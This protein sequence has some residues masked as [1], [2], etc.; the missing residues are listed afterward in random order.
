MKCFNVNV[1]WK[2]DEA[3]YRKEKRELVLKTIEPICKAFGIQ[4][5]DYEY[6]SRK[7][8]LVLEDTRI[9]CA[10]NSIAATVK[11]LIS[12]IYNHYCTRG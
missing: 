1:M 3:G 9:C 12:F 4:K 10:C 7:E 2:N 11:E 8:D 6:T 5:Y